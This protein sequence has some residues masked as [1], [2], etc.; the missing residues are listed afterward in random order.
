MWRTISFSDRQ[1]IFDHLQTLSTPEHL[2][3]LVASWHE[4]T[5][6]NLV[7]RGETTSIRVGRGLRQG[8][9]IAPLLWVTFMDLFLQQLAA[10]VGFPWIMECLTIYADDVHVGC[11]FLSEFSLHT[12][13]TNIGHALDVI[14][15]MKLFL[16]VLQVVYAVCIHGHKSKTNLEEG[17][18][19]YFQRSF[20]PHPTNPW[21]MHRIAV[22][23]QRSLLGCGHQL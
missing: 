7:F 4:G 13:L 2:I 1:A 19:A 5:N 15:R 9:K 8:C 20:H 22:E 10:L 18:P 3:Q 14:E 11:Q 16:V 23:E 12:H 17:A 21:I 6:Y